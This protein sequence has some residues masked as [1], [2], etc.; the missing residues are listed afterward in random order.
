MA[1]SRRD[2]VLAHRFLMGRLSSGMLRDEP[3]APDTPLGR[4]SR[5]T[6]IGLVVGAVIALVVTLYGV[7]VP[8]GNTSWQT[9]GT[10]VVVSDT[11]ARYLYL[12]GQLRPVLN[13]TSA[14][15][16]AGSQFTIQQVAANSLDGTPR[17]PMIGLVGAPDSLTPA[18]GLNTGP[19]LACGTEQITDSGAFAP[20]LALQVGV[21]G[22]GQPLGRGQGLVVAGPDQSLYVISNGQRLRLDSAHGAT[23]ALGYAS[24]NPFPVTAGFLDTVPAGPDLAAPDVPGRGAAGPVLAGH[25]TAVGQLFSGAGNQ[26]YLLRADGL[27]P[28]TDTLFGLL[29]GDPRTQQAA[30]RGGPVA[31]NPIGPADV[32][33]HS[34]SGGAQASLTHDGA[35]PETPPTPVATP[36]GQGV[37]IQVQPNGAAP[38]TSV[39]LVDGN[40]VGGQAPARQL[41]VVPSCREPD[42]IAVRPGGGALVRALSTGGT[43]ANTVYLVSDAGVKYPVPSDDVV[44]QLGYD[45]AATVPLPATLLGMLPTGPSLD[46]AALAGGGMATQRTPAQPCS[47]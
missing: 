36:S 5:G 44:K 1:Q 24:V 16:I 3:D 30:Y 43:V 15:L 8:G 12:G 4:T 42:E 2:Q 20:R 7:I 14:R 34:A 28:L 25:P 35:L 31:A 6:V 41:G 39:F 45:P 38:I 18:T 19:W 33:A 27:V 17:G 26:H 13:Q 11:G 23:Q 32:A 29:R 40:T 10:M 37:C 22:T 21:P 9:P 46:P 47:S